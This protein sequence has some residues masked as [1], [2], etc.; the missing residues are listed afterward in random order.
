MAEIITFPVANRRAFLTRALA[1]AAGAAIAAGSDNPAAE[2]DPWRS[3]GEVVR[4]FGRAD[5]V[6][7]LARK[8]RALYAEEARLVEYSPVE[9][10]RE[11]QKDIWDRIGTVETEMMALVATSPAAIA[12]QVD[13]LRHFLSVSRYELLVDNVIT[14]L[15]AI[16]ATGDAA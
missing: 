7:L 15:R 6:M 16:A 9:P 8:R 11:V 4:T 1:G 14:G 13:I 3:L 12:E 10:V 2:H 5:P